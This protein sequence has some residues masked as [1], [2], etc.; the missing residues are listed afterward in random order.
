M[1]PQAAWDQLIE[2]YTQ[3]DWSAV[4]ELAEGLLHWLSRGGFPPRTV[5][6]LAMDRG[7]NLAV[8]ESACRFALSRVRA[9]QQEEVTDD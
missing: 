9:K 5:P 6:K 8:A 2:A 3:R 4:E 1:D 7:W